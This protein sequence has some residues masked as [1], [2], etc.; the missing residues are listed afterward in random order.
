[1]PTWDTFTFM[2]EGYTFIEDDTLEAQG[3]SYAYIDKKT[4]NRVEM[5]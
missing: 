5:R 2:Y 3:I 1:M 4:G